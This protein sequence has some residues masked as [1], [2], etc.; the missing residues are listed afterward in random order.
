MEF[1][2]MHKD[3]AVMKFLI[4]EDS[5]IKNITEIYNADHM[6]FST[7]GSTNNN[8]FAIKEWWKDRSIPITRDEYN[9]S[10]SNLPG[11]NSLSLVVKAHAL[12]LTDQ[13]W[14][15]GVDENI[16]YDD[17]SF[18]SNN[19]ADDIG[20]IFIG[21]KKKGTISY[22]SP[23]STSTGN[24]KKRWKTIAGQ[25]YLCKAGTKPYQY[26][27]FNEIIASKIMNIL[28][29][30]HVDY[31][32]TFDEDMMFC[33]SLDFISYNEDFV[34]AYQLSK[35][36]PKKNDV[37]LYD[38]LMS[39]MKELRIPDYQKKINQMLF[40]DYL[41]GNVDRHL[42]NFGVIRD[43]KTLQFVRFAPI[44]DSGSSFG[45]N[46][47][48]KDLLR[49]KEVD[50]LPFKSSKHKDQLSLIND[51][52]W[53]NNNA[54]ETIPKQIEQLLILHGEYISKERRNAI[55]NFLINRINDYYAYQHIDKKASL[56]SVDLTALEEDILFYTYCHGNKLTD[57][58]E[59]MKEFDIAYI[60]IYRAVSNLTK[61]GLL[62]RRG[63]R[64]N[65]YWV[66]P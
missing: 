16:R 58:D 64:K 20:D 53:L 63:A 12:S 7:K 14:I 45:Y 29:I 10:I 34:S 8:L 65:G 57:F 1:I 23:D 62:I 54:L 52:S 38:H 41:I 17:V 33:K 46:L 19:Y 4:D 49:L 15:K 5:D 36:K 37:S 28:D 40:V 27:I 66:L 59:L 26:E 48:D 22:Y 39:I 6:P 9:R 51:Y 35:Y 47:L 25:R 43:A 50:W 13:Y 61:K 56:H 11:E 31:D 30:D 21:K 42:S 44:F 18:F 24:L 32:L 2:L 60:T 3:I 55:I